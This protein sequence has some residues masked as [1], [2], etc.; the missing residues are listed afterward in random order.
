MRANASHP[1]QIT[2]NALDDEDPGLVAGRA[3]D[4]ARRPRSGA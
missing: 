4:R 2:F 3:Q 1:T